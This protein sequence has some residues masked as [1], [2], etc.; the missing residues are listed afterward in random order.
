[1]PLRQ[2]DTALPIPRWLAGAAS[3]VIAAHLLAIGGLALAA[4]SGPWSMP[5]GSSMERAPQ[6]ALDINE[7]SSYLVVLRMTHNY[8][9]LS[10]HPEQTGVYFE[11]Q[12]KDENGK[13][14]GSITFPDEKANLWLRHR[15]LLL[16]RGLTDDVPVQPPQGE[17]IAAP[18]QKAPS[19]E[20]WEPGEG[21]IATLRA[22]PEHLI[23]RNRPVFRPSEWSRLLARA[24]SRYLCRTHGAASV[25]IV[26][27]TKDPLYPGVL[28]T[29]E[30]AVNPEEFVASFGDVKL[31][32]EK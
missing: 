8:H 24:Y 21:K 9:F 10:N 11:A 26:R 3:V 13:L 4:Q 2:S 23:P 14:L 16:A 20:I 17:E 27:H 12:L 1:M 22:V 32:V 5:L 29:K 30:A 18:R 25:E 15:Q 31:A 28:L 19:T 7:M 6:F